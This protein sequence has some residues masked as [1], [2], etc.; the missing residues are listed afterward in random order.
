MLKLDQLCFAFNGRPILEDISFRLGRGEMAA[1]L[2]VN[3]SGK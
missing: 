2:G 1:L 3:G